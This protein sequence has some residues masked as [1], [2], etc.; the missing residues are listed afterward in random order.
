MNY[1]KI[2]VLGGGQ[3]GRMLQEKAL[4]YGLDLYFLDPDINCP[5]RIFSQ[6][7]VQGDFRDY[8][9]VLDF[10]K[11][12]DIL[13]IE[14]EHVDVKALYELEKLGKTIIP[15]ARVIDL[16]QNKAKQKEF[17]R[18]NF[19][20]TADFIMGSSND[21]SDE[22]KNFLP[23]FQKS[24]KE[25]YDG[26]GVQWL[27][28]ENLDKQLKTPYLLEKKV[29]ISQELALTFVRTQSG[30][31]IFY[32][33]SAME[34]SQ[35]LNLLEYLI[36]PAQI[37]ETVEEELLD[38]ASKI[39]DGLDSPGLYSVEF[40]LDNSEKVWVNEIA[41]RAHNSAHY[42]IE[43]CNISQF[44]AQIRI[45]L[46]LP[47]PAIELRKPASMINLLGASE[48][49]GTPKLIGHE[50]LALFSEAHLH[51]YGKSQSK[52]GRKMGHVTLLHANI[53]TLREETKAL[54][55][56]LEIQLI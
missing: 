53:R 21:I 44:E 35:D 2:G 41:P 10:G 9:S 20:P 15:S 49:S 23:A 43:A 22:E 27:T 52:P 30:Q 17:Y 51:L 16:I 39:S 24:Q 36:V 26:K 48:H 50:A 28:L 33:I 7:F 19:I 55:D 4:A 37:K 3:L 25:G 38:I 13:T 56:K 45:L 42:T 1:P 32:P 29:D 8:Q 5:C 40:F 47:F 12:L 6:N 31:T 34:F 14:I 46:N 11:T 18:Q 54:K